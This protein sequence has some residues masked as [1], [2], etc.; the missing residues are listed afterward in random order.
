MEQKVKGEKGARKEERGVAPWR[1][2]A[3]WP[4][5][6]RFLR[7]MGD[8][9]FPWPWA[10]RGEALGGALMPALD[11]R[12]NDHHYAVTVELP[13]VGKDDVHV[14]IENGLLTIR[15]E[16]RSE[17]EEKKERSHYTERSYG[18]FTRTLRLPTDADADR[19]EASFKDGVLALKIPRTEAA[20]PRTIAIKGS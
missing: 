7:S 16:K 8:D 5:P 13:G 6:S 12:E 15:G 4:F 1:P 18:A 10:V 17:R 9:L 19:L 14:E 11:V 20:K 3:E 2:F